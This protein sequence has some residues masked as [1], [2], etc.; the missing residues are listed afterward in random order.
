MPRTVEEWATIQFSSTYQIP[1]LVPQAK[2]PTAQGVQ[3]LPEPCKHY[4]HSARSN[5]YQSRARRTDARME[6]LSSILELSESRLTREITSAAM[7]L[8]RSLDP[9]FKVVVDNVE[10]RY[11]HQAQHRCTS[12]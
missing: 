3:G 8:F 9:D 6:R 10:Q 1:V 5:A 11:Y 7:S 12:L 4:L 2:H